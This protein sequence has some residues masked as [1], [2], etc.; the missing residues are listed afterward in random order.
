M[1]RMDVCCAYFD[2]DYE[3]LNERIYGTRVNVDNDS[4]GKCTVV[5]VNSRNDHD[6][7]LEV[8]EVLIGLE[9]SIAKCYIS[10]DAGWFMDVFHVRDQEGNKVYSKKAINYIEQAICT[11]DSRRFTVTRS[12]ELAS[13]PDVAAHYTGIEMIGHNR[14]GIFSEISAVLAEQGCSV[15][16][17]HAWSHKDSLACVA[18]VSDESTASRISDPNRLASIQDHLGTVL[19]PGTS[20]DEDGRSARAH[21]LGPDGLTSHPERRLH[22]LMFASKDFDGQQG[23]VST[24]F[25]MLSLDGY[26]KGRG[27][28]VSVDRCNE[29]GYSVVNVECVDRPK[30]MFDTVC[31][32]TDMQFN[33]FHASVSSRGPFA[34]Q[35]YYIRHRDGHMLDTLDERCLVMKGVKAAVERRTCEG[36]KLELC[37]EN[38]AGLLSYITRVLRENGLTVTQA[39]IAMDGDKMKNTFYVQGI[40]DNKIDMDVVESVRR[41]LDPLPFQ[42][43]DDELL[44]RGQLE[45]E[46]VAERN[47][48]CIL[49]LLRS[50]IESLSH[51]FISSG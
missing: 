17:A 1:R 24:A 5:N 15:M 12:N 6:L 13:R 20:M 37:T 29:K 50:K 28:V 40:S 35:E 9:L 23:Q 11:R 47:G 22:Q 43:K 16:E 21:L 41:E 48:F 45:G 14:P 51:G 49:S 39:D 26:K 34:C 8:L 44:S 4:C 38:T 18:F 7:L 19:G 10:S 31:T 27:A 46:P 36:V 3:N 33:V 25:P 30:L 42:V 32:L 2:P